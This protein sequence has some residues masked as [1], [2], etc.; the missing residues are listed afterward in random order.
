M[1]KRIDGERLIIR[2]V[3]G[4]GGKEREVPITPE[5]LG[6]LRTFWKSHRN[7]RWSR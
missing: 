5:L 7:P 1:T 2:I 6:R 3:N 4:K